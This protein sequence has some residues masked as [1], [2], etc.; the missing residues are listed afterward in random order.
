MSSVRNI[1][2]ETCCK[3]VEPKLLLIHSANQACRPNFDLLSHSLSSL[4]ACLWVYRTWNLV[5]YRVRSVSSHMLPTPCSARKPSIASEV[6][7]SSW[8]T[9]S[10]RVCRSLSVGLTIS[11]SRLRWEFAQVTISLS[12]LRWTFA[13]VTISLSRLRWGFAQE[14]GRAHVWNSSHKLTLISYAVS[15]DRKSVV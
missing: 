8:C 9:K 3:C 11:L 1:T 5:L 6:K 7:G 15:L 2:N 10:Y 12:R 14:I 13:Q 4:Q